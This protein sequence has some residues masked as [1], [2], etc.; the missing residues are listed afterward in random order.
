MSEY[1]EIP[2]REIKIGNCKFTIWSEGKTYDPEL[3]QYRARYSYSIETDEWKYDANDIHGA[4]NRPPDLGIAS[5]ALLSLFLTCVQAKDSDDNSLLFP[6]YVRKA[7]QEI[8]DDLI[9]VCNN[10]TGE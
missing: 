10:L 6:D 1:I 4:A 7:G 5:T 3:E 9:I 8:E 2:A